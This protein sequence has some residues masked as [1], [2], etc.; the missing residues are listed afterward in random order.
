MKII[1]K[2]MAMMLIV[3]LVSFSGWA[4]TAK[5]LSLAPHAR[6]EVA[7]AHAVI[8]PTVVYTSNYHGYKVKP[9]QRKGFGYTHHKKHAYHK[10]K[11]R[12][13]KHFSHNHFR[14]PYVKKKRHFVHKK[15]RKHHHAKKF[16]GY[17][18]RDFYRNPVRSKFFYGY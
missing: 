17:S 7:N 2:R 6:Q 9:Y 15:H 13:K 4:S 12:S 16:G 10:K 14:K 3:A 8:V 1:E 5:A 18:H 11:Y